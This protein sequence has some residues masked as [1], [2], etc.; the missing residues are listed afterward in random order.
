MGILAFCGQLVGSAPPSVG[1]LRFS[2]QST[3][4]QRCNRGIVEGAVVWRRD[5]EEPKRRSPRSA[6][7]RVAVPAGKHFINVADTEAHPTVPS[8]N[9]SRKRAKLIEAGQ[10][11]PDQ[12]R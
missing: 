10:I 7:H 12:Q 9:R 1:I 8:D 4:R 3:G 5:I 11:A 6:I 2:S